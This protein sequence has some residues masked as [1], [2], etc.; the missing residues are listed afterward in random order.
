MDTFSQSANTAE[1]DA[2]LSLVH[3]KGLNVEMNS[4][5][6]HLNNNYANLADVLKVLRPVLGAAGL[7]VTQFPGKFVSS[8][9]FT[10]IEIINRIGHK[11]GQWMHAT[12]SIPA[13]DQKGVTGAQR[14]GLA[15]TYAKRYAL[16]A[17][18]A[19]TTGDDD[20]DGEGAGTSEDVE[21]SRG[22]AVNH[23]KDADT[24]PW[25]SL[26]DGA[27]QAI[28]V[29][30]EGVLFGELPRD[31]LR[32][33]WGLAI[34]TEKIGDKP[35]QKVVASFYDDLMEVTSLRRMTDDET[36][37]QTLARASSEWPAAQMDPLRMTMR[38][39]NMAYAAISKLP[40]Q[41]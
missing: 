27:W 35:N 32:E 19:M 20:D 31:R 24:V 2:A 13:P 15:L 6:P 21:R 4:V 11:S 7:S 41:P 37:A 8:D 1:L 36:F 26:T 29:P 17:L 12:M 34:K 22:P 3:A 9:G 14:Y 18:F 40:A 5:N 28:E 25:Q 39:L 10:C 33:L 30:G 23:T 38:T 16:I